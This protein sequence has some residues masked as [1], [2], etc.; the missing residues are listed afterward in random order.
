MSELITIVG[1]VAMF[2]I[3]GMLLVGVIHHSH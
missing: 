1:G 3:V 2:T